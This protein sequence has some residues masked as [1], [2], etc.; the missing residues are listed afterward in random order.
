MENQL[1]LQEILTK[2]LLIFIRI[3]LGTLIFK[4]YWWLFLQLIFN[5]EPISLLQSLICVLGL[6]LI[7]KL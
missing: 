6:R 3:T 1:R 4:V 2:Y 7:R 5:L